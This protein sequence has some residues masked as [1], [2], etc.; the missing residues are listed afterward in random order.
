MNE[1]VLHNQIP[2]STTNRNRMTKKLPIA[3]ALLSFRWSCCVVCVILVSVPEMVSSFASSSSSSSSVSW[4]IPETL[5]NSPYSP[6]LQRNQ[7]LRRRHHHPIGRSQNRIPTHIYNSNR[8]NDRNK[9]NNNNNKEYN[10]KTNIEIPK[11][12]KSTFWYSSTPKPKPPTLPCEPMLDVDGPL[13]T[14]SYRI[15]NDNDG[16][17]SGS[18]LSRKRACLL[19]INL[20]IWKRPPVPSSKKKGGQRQTGGGGD[21]DVILSHAI[22]N[23]QTLID[24]GFTS[25]QISSPSILSQSSSSPTSSA[26]NSIL[27]TMTEQLIYANLIRETPPSVLRL[28]NLGTKIDI[29]PS[30]SS[31]TNNGAAMI[32]GGNDRDN[33]FYD[34]T[35]TFQRTDVRE[36]I[37]TSIRNMY[38]STMGQIDTLQVSFQPAHNGSG[39]EA[40]P[41]TY[42][43]L[44]VL[45][46]LQREGHVSSILGL[47]FTPEA[48]HKAQEL[49]FILDGN[50]ID[51]NLV[52]T[53]T[54]DS[55]PS[56]TATT[57]RGGGGLCIG[58]P[59]AGGLLT[60]RYANLLDRY[61]DRRGS[62]I[63]GYM[64]VSER[65]YFESWVRNG[66]QS[67]KRSRTTT[68][69]N[70]E[71]Q[72]QE[73]RRRRSKGKKVNPTETSWQ[74]FERTVLQ[75]LDSIAS[76][77]RVSIS[78]V[79]I[80]WSMH[81][82]PHHTPTTTGGC[83]AVAIRSDLGA[84]G[85]GGG[86]GDSSSP[87]DD[88]GRLFYQAQDLRQAFTFE[89]DEEDLDRLAGI[90]GVVPPPPQLEEQALGDGEDGFNVGD[91]KGLW[92]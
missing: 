23:A 12:I 80:R 70:E 52:D 45:S 5:T 55:F 20:D 29:P 61:R 92:L 3:M 6:P 90:S 41:Y 31:N 47:N 68:P 86:G 91:Y 71:E 2:T 85:G 65:Y 1:R 44:D 62:P 77:H 8:N 38:G 10:D 39:G 89:L 4:L 42:D 18:L 28:C 54:Y 74:R 37:G 78:S 22:T 35:N 67:K 63:P 24:G 11:N 75:P 73:D 81:L 79:A 58:S 82:S 48:M 59:T 66:G 51:C 14:G 19:T 13:P 25:F 84:R 33:Y 43:V 32:R 88:D 15:L 69:E 49:G 60:G 87:D 7:L 16:S 53:A 64:T 36:K 17:G 76:K 34:N 56:T 21:D 46:D 50:Q 83:S 30:S 40:S 72:E 9:N 57:T 27:Q 26:A